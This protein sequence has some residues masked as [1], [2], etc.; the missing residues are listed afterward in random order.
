MFSAAPSCSVTAYSAT[1]PPV[2]LVQ[3][4]QSSTAWTFTTQNSTT[5][6]L[7]DTYGE[8]LCMGPRP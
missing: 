2:A 7:F 5:G 1:A 6:A 8:I 4:T 3:S